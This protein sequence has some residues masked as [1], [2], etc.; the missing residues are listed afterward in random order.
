MDFGEVR[1]S[2]AEGLNIFPL[3]AGI[4]GIKLMVF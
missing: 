1:G 2:G 4:L 3:A